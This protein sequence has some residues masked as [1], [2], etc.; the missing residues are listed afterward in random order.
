MF[1]K[2]SD[3]FIFKQIRMNSDGYSDNLFGH[4]LV[5]GDFATK[6]LFRLVYL[7]RTLLANS[8]ATRSIRE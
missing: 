7:L 1:S 6:I 4:G 3:V 2:S 8:R 5:A